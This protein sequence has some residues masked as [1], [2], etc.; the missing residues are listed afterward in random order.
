MDIYMKRLNEKHIFCEKKKCANILI[1][2]WKNK[3][4][5]TIYCT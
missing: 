2:T 4:V 5:L 3:R 1:Y